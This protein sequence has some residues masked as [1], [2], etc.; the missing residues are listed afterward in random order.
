MAPDRWRRLTRIGFAPILLFLAAP[1]T[2]TG[3][4]S[5]TTI[6]PSTVTT[7]TTLRSLTRCDIVLFGPNLFTP[8]PE[9]DR[10]IRLF[11]GLPQIYATTDA[12]VGGRK[13]ADPK[14][15]VAVYFAFDEGR[16]ADRSVLRRRG[17]PTQ[18]TVQAGCDDLRR[19]SSWLGA[20]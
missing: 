15:N 14:R 4:S 8:G 12:R 5:T 10:V 11:G 17:G 19:H 16:F 18:R 6:Q 13:S 7:S 20:A 1:T 2:T 3:P 9:W